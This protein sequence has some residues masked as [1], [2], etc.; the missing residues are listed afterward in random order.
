[1]SLRSKVCIDGLINNSDHKAFKQP[2]PEYKK[3]ETSKAAKKNHDAKIIYA[4]TDI[5][6]VI[7]MLDPIESLCMTSPNDDNQP[8]YDAEDE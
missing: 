2:L 6:N 8:N 7:G 4:Y 3:G 1:M 5:D